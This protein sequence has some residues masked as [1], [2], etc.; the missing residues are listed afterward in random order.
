[1]LKRVYLTTVLL[2]VL[3]LGNANAAFA[4]NQFRLVDVDDSGVPD[5]CLTPF[6][7]YA[8]QHNDQRARDIRTAFESFSNQDIQNT[9]FFLSLSGKF[10][11]SYTRTGNDAVP[12]L[13]AN[14]NNIPD[15]IEKAAQ[16]ADE[17]YDYL[18]NERGFVDPVL[19]GVP[20]EIRFREINSYGFTQ[21]QGATSFIVVHRNFEDF[22]ANNDPDGDQ[23]GALKVTIA[24]E[25][26]HAIQYATSRWQ[27]NSGLTNWLEM[28]ATMIEE[29]VYPEVDDYVNYL[30]VCASSACSVFRDPNRSTPGSYYHAT[31]MLY[32][33]L[34]IDDTFWVDVWDEIRVSP[35]SV[36]MFSAI[37]QALRSRN[38]NFTREFTRNHLWH[39]AS[40]TNSISGYG[41]PDA[42]LFPNPNTRVIALIE[43]STQVLEQ[44]HQ[45][46]AAQYLSV[47]NLDRQFGEIIFQAEYEGAVMGAGILSYNQDGT[48]TERIEA[49]SAILDNGFVRMTTGVQAQNTDK[50]IAVLTNPG[51]SRQNI[52]FSIFARELPQE[53]T[54]AQNFPNPFNPSTTIPFTIPESGAVRL[55]I[56]D[57]TGRLIQTLVNGT[58]QPGFYDITFRGEGLASGVYLYRLSG[59]GAN[60]IGKMLLLK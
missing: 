25:F 8:E 10:L 48:W 36:T 31:W 49:G 34:A 54:L 51:N 32:F 2:S 56:F 21:S 60:R 43:D 11:L 41:F 20:Y 45:I 3:L 38:L 14:T 53:I 15:Y 5:K 44:E 23:L 17:S 33:D 52:D 18:V 22:P 12:S 30:N 28:D 4:Q 7:I 58:L 6:A 35:Q 57:T 46:Y 26:K 13:D 29:V 37:D 24:H 40:G 39:A 9:E 1:M 55:D 27:G 47:S 42:A 16:Y 59:P 50:L 19:P